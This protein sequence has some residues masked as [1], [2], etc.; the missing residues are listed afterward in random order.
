M[1]H[2]FKA[3]DGLRGVAA[4]AVV[5]THAWKLLDVQPLRHG[6]LAVDFFFLLSGF[7][8]AVAYQDRISAGFGFADFWKARIIRLYPLVLVGSLSGAATAYFVYD[9]PL[10]RLML[11]T[12]TQALFLPAPW[13]NGLGFG[14]WP[15]DPPAWSLFW[16]LVASAAFA[17]WMARAR[18]T[19][20]ACVASISA[21][22]L[23]AI[24]AKT[25]TLELGFT[26]AT[27]WAGVFRVSFAFTIGVLLFRAYRADR[28]PK[29][30]VH[31]S[32]VACALL[33]L[34]AYPEQSGGVE[35]LSALVILPVLLT[36]AISSRGEG[37][38]WEWS[39]RI[40]YPIYLLHYPVLVIAE[41]S[42]FATGGMASRIG[43][44][45]LY[46]SA[47]LCLSAVVLVFYDEPFR[48]YLRRRIAG[49]PALRPSTLPRLRPAA[50]EQ[51]A[52]ST[53]GAVSIP[54]SALARALSR[55]ARKAVSA[56]AGSDAPDRRR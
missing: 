24:A 37:A 9:P 39:G 47:C 52:S 38:F 43:V 14:L 25:S 19:S 20:L 21:L 31:V 29:L 41:T 4:I 22:A 36:L 56:P 26:R 1:H 30:E 18:T 54:M 44:A 23:C 6:Y 17:L 32:I 3:L 2:H 51:Q 34:F 7:V 27:F 45:T 35:A 8:I 55:R 10:W 50:A 12:F 46:V 49:A 48:A 15:L 11:A 40:S 28:L 42:G 13:E 16:E 53:T 5:V 33:A